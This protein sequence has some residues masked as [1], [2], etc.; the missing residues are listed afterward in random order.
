MLT[1]NK[2]KK[3]QQCSPGSSTSNSFLHE[4]P[5]NQFIDEEIRAQ[6]EQRFRKSK[7][8]QDYVFPRG[9]SRTPAK[10]TPVKSKPRLGKQES[11]KRLRSLRL[12]GSMQKVRHTRN[13]SEAL[14]T[15]YNS[16]CF[17][18]V[19]SV[20]WLSKALAFPKRAGKPPK[21]RQFCGGK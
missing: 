18:S 21:P 6:I 2:L 20:A 16:P 3:I 12:C 1:G 19:A 14:K 4:T 13:C 17:N 10:K 11:C 9:K 15:A 8:N 7:T 5:R